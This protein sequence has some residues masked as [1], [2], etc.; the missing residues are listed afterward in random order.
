MSKQSLAEYVNQ[1]QAAGRYTF[2]TVEAQEAAELSRD[3]LKKSLSRLEEQKRIVV[4]R[5][6]FCVIVPLEYRSSGILPPDWFIDD[7]MR[8]LGQPY[9]VAL[10]SA[11]ELHGAAHQRPQTFQVITSRAIREAEAAGLR[12]RFFKKANMAAT[13]QVKKRTFTGDIPVSSPA[14]TALDLVAYERRIGRLSRVMTVLQE[15]GEGIEADSLVAAAQAGEQLAHV[16]R[17]G[18]LLDKVGFGRATA[19]LQEWLGCRKTKAV[20]LDP[21]RPAKGFMRDPKWGVIVNAEVE[22]EL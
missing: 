10:L 22:G 19:K 21:S 20:A 6:G 14:A 4:V 18:W 5:R 12:I 8:F 13:P 1:I 9:Y 7:L 3:A 11:A 2:T 16:Q 15:L 17:L